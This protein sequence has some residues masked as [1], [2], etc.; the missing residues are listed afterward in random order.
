MNAIPWEAVGPILAFLGAVLGLWWRIES[1]IEKAKELAAKQVETAIALAN[2]MNDDRGDEIII[3]AKDLADYKLAASERFA[4][5]DHL[6]EVEVRL[7]VAV[8]R[9]TNRIEQLP[10]KFA[11]EVARLVAPKPSRRS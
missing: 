6:K 10:N 8:D 11:E 1:S 4:S 3:V 5:Q 9:L 2:K 7:T